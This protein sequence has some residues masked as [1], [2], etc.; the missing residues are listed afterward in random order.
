MSTFQPKML[1]FHYGT[2]SSNNHRRVVTK[3]FSAILRESLDLRHL[4]RR[5]TA[6]ERFQLIRVRIGIWESF[7]LVTF[8]RFFALLYFIS[9]FLFFCHP[10]F[11]GCKSSIHQG[12]SGFES[13]SKQFFFRIWFL[14][15]HIKR[16]IGIFF[17]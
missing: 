4:Y 15:I 14:L 16:R 11:K 6:D 3:A 2:L 8:L 10:N 7:W 5:T 1:K 17:P 13:H 12:G 9:D